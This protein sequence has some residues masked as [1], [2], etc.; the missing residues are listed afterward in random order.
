MTTTASTP[1]DPRIGEVFDS[2]PPW[3]RAMALSL[4][5]LVFDVARSNTALEPLEETL[6]WG[7][8]SYLAAQKRQGTT[9]RIAWSKKRPRQVGLYFNCQTSLLDTFTTLFPE[10]KCEGDRAIVFEQGEILPKAELGTCIEAAFTYHR[11][12]DKGPAVLPM[13]RHANRRI[14]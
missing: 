4:R 6:K 14:T 2:Y 13:R 7:E 9:V 1:I 3:A 8:P 5:E 12:K 10:L 11:W